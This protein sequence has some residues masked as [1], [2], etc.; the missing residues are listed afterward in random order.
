[1]PV[2][3]TVDFFQYQDV[4]RKKTHILVGYYILAVVF[5]IVAIYLAFIAVFTGAQLKAGGEFMVENLWKPQAFMWVVGVTVAIVLVGTLYKVLEMGKGGEAVALMLGGRPIDPGTADLHERKILNIVEEMAIASGM[6][7]PRVFLLEGEDS[8][9]AF[10]AGFSTNDCIIGVTRGC[11]ARLNRD[12]LQGVIAHEFSHILNGDM[13]LNIRLIGVLNGILI[14]AMIGLWILRGLGRSRSSSSRSKGGGAVAAIALFA[15]LLMVIGYIGVFFGKLIKSAVSRQREFLADASAVQF[16]RNPFGIANALKKIGG[17]VAGSRITNV[18]AEEAS[19]FFFSNGLASSWFNLMAT[20]PSLEERIRRLDPQFDGSFDSV[21]APAEATVEPVP[22]M[23]GFTSGG[24]QRISLKPGDVVARVGAPTPEH[25]DYA[26]RLMSS[27]PGGWNEVIREPAGACAVIYTLLLSQDEA[28]R[29]VQLET[30]GRN[31]GV[32]V[33]ERMKTVL[34]LAE[35]IKPEIRL[36]VADI[37]IAT[38][39]SL[40]KEDYAVFAENLKQLVNADKQIDLFEY[41]LQRMVQRRL[42]PTFN[43]VKPAA[44]QYH[45]LAPLV[46]AAAKLLSCVAYWGADELPAAQKAFA[47]GV[48]K[49]G[50]GEVAMLPIDQCGLP[51]LD[52][53][54]TE[55]SAASPAIKRAVI[56]ASTVCIGADGAVR[57][58]EAELLRAIG[59]A[60]DCPIPPFLPGEKV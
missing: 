8:I 21:P 5:I 31:A 10:A 28:V 40:S 9:N 52:E 54:L 53:A 17:I 32:G 6:P 12:E 47:A 23:A 49:L 35:G 37:S 38:M 29:S 3:T 4:A 14:I 43:K 44:I 55:F 48:T 33:S 50:K 18:H 7:V 19:H 56:A 30:L 20:H 39:K 16:T 59:D 24:S 13:R 57:R 22:A 36:P 2:S 25:L 46:P 27:L 58:E 51:A 11:I 60:L 42:E 45:D 26:T 34:P 15:F 1:M 41:T